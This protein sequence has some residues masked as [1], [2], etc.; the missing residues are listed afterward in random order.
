M[1]TVR[2][3]VQL[4]PEAPFVK[5]LRVTFLGLPRVRVEVLPLK[6]NLADIPILSGFVQSSIE[7]ALAE[8]CAPSSLTLDVGE[9][10]MGDSVKR[11]VN[12]L[13]VIVVW[14]HRAYDLEKQ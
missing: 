10:L 3:R 8:Y 4:S 12:A 13:G 14:I 11:E 7:A 5:N 9:I 6:V 2:A 1:G